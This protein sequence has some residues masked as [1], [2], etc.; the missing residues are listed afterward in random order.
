MG[1]RGVGGVGGVGDSSEPPSQ[2]RGHRALADSG[3][4]ECGLC[5]GDRWGVPAIK[6]ILQA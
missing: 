2:G 5:P 3:L 4:Q 6:M 1:L